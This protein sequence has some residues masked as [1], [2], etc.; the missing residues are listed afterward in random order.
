MKPPAISPG[1]SS[2]FFVGT[3]VSVFLYITA[4]GRE[5]TS[6]PLFRLP[7]LCITPEY[8]GQQFCSFVTLEI[9]GY[10]MGHSE[11]YPLLQPNRL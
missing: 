8:K 11:P 3:S 7:L 10:A 1:Y 9:K 5:S 4:R 6:Y 2:G